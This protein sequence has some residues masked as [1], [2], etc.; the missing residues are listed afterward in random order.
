MAAK[1]RG[2]REHPPRTPEPRATTPVALEWTRT[3]GSLGGKTH[4]PGPLPC[5]PSSRCPGAP[6][7]SGNRPH[8][9]DAALSFRWRPRGARS[10][11]RRPLSARAARRLCRPK[12]ARRLTSANASR[13]WQTASRYVLGQRLQ[14]SWH[15]LP[16]G[17]LSPN[18]EVMAPSSPSS[19]GSGGRDAPAPIEGGREGGGRALPASPPARTRRSFLPASPDGAPLGRVGGG[20]SS[21]LRR[22]GGGSRTSPAASSLLLPSLLLPARAAPS[23][24]PARLRRL[25]PPRAVTLGDSALAT[26]AAPAPAHARPSDADPGVGRRGAGAGAAAAGTRARPL[27]AAPSA[28]SGGRPIHTAAGRNQ[29]GAREGAAP[30]SPAPGGGRGWEGG[31]RGW[32]AGGDAAS[33]LLSSCQVNREDL[34]FKKKFFF[35]V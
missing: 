19:G 20:G 5:S 1:L 35:N 21:G 2:Q 15:T 13:T 8:E 10:P 3:H 12:F 24:S 27:P 11:G 34:Q 22:A 26:F 29:V 16:R 9:P 28:E 14:R 30:A 25:H 33:G 6:N 7:F 17:L 32:R 4:N 23:P 18:S 31:K